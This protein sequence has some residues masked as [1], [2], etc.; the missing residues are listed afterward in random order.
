MSKK[1]DFRGFTMIEMVVVLAVIAILAAILTPI[2]TSYVD[3]ARLNAAASDLHNIAAATIQF[4]TDTKLW[5][6]YIGVFT[7][8]NGP[9]DDL[10]GTPG[11]DAVAGAGFAGFTAS[12]SGSLDAALNQNSMGLPT[13]G[14]NFW[15]GAYLEMGP[16]PWGTKYY[17]TSKHLQP[18]STFAAYVI[19]AG[20]NQTLET[21]F[22]QP[23][24]GTLTIAGDDIVVRIK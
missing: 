10:K 23:Q 11:N 14:K 20:P 21:A 5:P 24:S 12:S 8:L 16:D 2:I 1:R 4:N 15:R 9:V 6:I 18:G 3:R 7:S 13:S 17:L 22:N 19:S